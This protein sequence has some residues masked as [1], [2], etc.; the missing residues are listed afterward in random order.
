MQGCYFYGD[1]PFSIYKC[2]QTTAIKSEIM[3]TTTS[4]DH[5]TGKSA[6]KYEAFFLWQIKHHKVM[7]AAGSCSGGTGRLVMA[8]E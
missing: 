7:K 4:N 5:Y 2:C 1:I 8:N 6:G 3:A